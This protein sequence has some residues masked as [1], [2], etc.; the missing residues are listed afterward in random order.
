MLAEVAAAVLLGVLALWLV[1]WPMFSPGS[2]TPRAEEPIDP[3][4]TR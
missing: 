2:S 4:E 3:E 1:L